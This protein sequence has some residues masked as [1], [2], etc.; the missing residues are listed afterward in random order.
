MHHEDG[1]TR[2][3]QTLREEEEAAN[4]KRNQ[5]SIDIVG[6]LDRIIERSYFGK[7]KF[8]RW[9]DRWVRLIA[10]GFLIYILLKLTVL[11]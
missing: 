1:F 2:W 4:A 11:K 7:T 10:L 3:Q 9:L 6:P 5:T 8:V